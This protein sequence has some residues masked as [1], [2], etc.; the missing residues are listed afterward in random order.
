GRQLDRAA[1]AVRVGMDGRTF[2]VDLVVFDKDGTLIDFH[3]LWDTRCR[4]AIE[5]LCTHVEAS[6][7]LEA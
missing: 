3:G 7:Q 5:R 1:L 2:D 6:P 4:D